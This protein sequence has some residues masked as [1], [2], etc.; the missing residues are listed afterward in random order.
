MHVVLSNEEQN[1]PEAY[2]AWCNL[3]WFHNCRDITGDVETHYHDAAE[4]WLWHEGTAEGVVDG[5]EVSGFGFRDGPAGWGMP[6]RF[7]SQLLLP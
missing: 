5:K 4:I 7:L 1:R 2:P 6:I 3:S